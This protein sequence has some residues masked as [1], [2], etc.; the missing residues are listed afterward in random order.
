VLQSLLPTQ[1][2]AKNAAVV[3]P[4]NARLKTMV[5]MAPYA[6]YAVWLD[7]YTGFVDAQ[8]QQVSTDFND[9]LHP[10]AAGYRIWR[11]R[12]VPFLDQQRAQAK[13]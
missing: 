11:D 2:E 10:N 7:L 4:V 3:R 6:S 9:G 13:P 12:L 5:A 8:G 1:E